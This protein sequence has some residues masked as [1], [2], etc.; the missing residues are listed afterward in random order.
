[1]DILFPILVFVIAFLYSS[2]GHGGAS[3]YL[4]LMA[5]FGVAPESMRS[6]SL[7]LNVFV[8][9]IAFISY[10]RAG[11]FQLKL[12]LPFIAASVPCA[13]LGALVKINPSVY[14]IILGIFLLFAVGR[15][16]FVPKAITGSSSA[17]PLWI[18]L[19]TGAILGFFSGMIGIGGGII[20]SPLLIL[21]HWAG[22]KETAAASA[23]FILLN[24]VSGLAALN[25]N[26]LHFE[27]Q[28]IIW[29]VMG[30][31]GGLAG[32]YSGSF[33][34][35]PVLLRYPLALVLLVASIKL[36]LV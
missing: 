18:A 17:P 35:K 7:A 8:A 13:F 26:G 28:M 3:G 15:L 33:K 25:I 32:S 21:L 14:K 5:L 30:I 2:V 36:L 6:T 10:Y 4:A 27:N 1:M 23:F 22:M 16:L 9:G 24:S 31:L 19:L 34:I 20:L 11:H 29:I 12:I